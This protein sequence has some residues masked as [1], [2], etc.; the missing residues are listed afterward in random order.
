MSREAGIETLCVGS[1]GDS[2]PAAL[3]E[4]IN[5]FLHGRGHPSVRIVVVI[6]RYRVRDVGLNV[7]ELGLDRRE[8]AD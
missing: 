4:T 5:G 7:A 1:H 3:A 2:Y 8:R 6:R